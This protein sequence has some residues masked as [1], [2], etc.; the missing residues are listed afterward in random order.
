MNKIN[1]AVFG[2]GVVGSALIKIIEKNKFVINGSKIH[3][4]G[5][6]ASNKNKKEFLIQKNNNWIDSL[7]SLDDLKVDLIVELVGGTDKFVNSIY[8]YA[9]K[10]NISYYC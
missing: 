2:L 4:V 10:K 6:K 3:I 7:S 9:V 1:I 8:K 5:I